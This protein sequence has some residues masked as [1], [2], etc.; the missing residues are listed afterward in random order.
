M[1]RPAS[2]GCATIQTCTILFPL[3]DN[4]VLHETLKLKARIWSENETST[5]Q[6]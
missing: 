2:T 5:V 6:G 4:K 3:E 1:P